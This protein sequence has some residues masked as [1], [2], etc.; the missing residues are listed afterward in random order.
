MKTTKTTRTQLAG[1]CLAGWCVIAGAACDRY[2]PQ[3]TPTTQREPEPDPAERPD[4]RLAAEAAGAAR[5]RALFEE[6]MRETADAFS[7][8]MQ[9]L[10]A[11]VAQLPAPRQAEEKQMLAEL[12]Q[13]LAA[14]RAQIAG[15]EK[16]GAAHWTDHRKAVLGS[17]LNVQG[18]L[19]RAAERVA[20][21]NRIPQHPILP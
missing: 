4:E 20:P 5:E 19:N 1:L 14:F 11:A 17:S 18:H 6:N 9:A 10:Q 8:E 15:L 13:M 16:A 12:E 21:Q 2:R 3:Q 7:R